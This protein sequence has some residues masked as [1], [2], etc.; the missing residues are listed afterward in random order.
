MNTYV[1]LQYLVKFFFYNDKYFE[2]VGYIK[3]TTHFSQSIFFFFPENRAVYEICRKTHNALLLF[4]CQ[5]TE[6]R[7]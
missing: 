1:N 2:V 4:H 5:L 7:T 3:T 6:P